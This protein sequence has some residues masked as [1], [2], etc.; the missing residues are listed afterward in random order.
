M[1]CTWKHC[2]VVLGTILNPDPVFR[3]AK[4]TFSVILPIR[5]SLIISLTFVDQVHPDAAMG[6]FATIFFCGRVLCRDFAYLC[7]PSPFV[8]CHGPLVL[9]NT[10]ELL[11]EVQGA[12]LEAI[13]YK[14]NVDAFHSMK[15]RLFF[16]SSMRVARLSGADDVDRAGRWGCVP[17]VAD[18]S[19]DEDAVACGFRNVPLVVMSPIRVLLLVR[20]WRG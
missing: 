1:T 20:H 4:N 9:W 15:K 2:L 10:R 12:N 17:G 8:V 13:P 11:S 3:I 14:P 5:F 6:Y 7:R 19:G 16:Y 18:P